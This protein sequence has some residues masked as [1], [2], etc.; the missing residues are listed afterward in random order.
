MDAFDEDVLDGYRDG[1]RDERPQ[2]PESLGN[3][4]EAYIFGW[5]N[6]R[7]DRLKQPRQSADA[8]RTHASAIQRFYPAPPG[9]TSTQGD[10]K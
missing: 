2:L 5:L 3:R 10:R 6:G 7:D 9:S 4:T 1:F 8:L